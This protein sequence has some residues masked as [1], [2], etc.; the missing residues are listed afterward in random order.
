MSFVKSVLGATV[1]KILGDRAYWA[2]R[3]SDGSWRSE[4]DTRHEIRTG[5]VRPFDWSLDL[6]DTGDVLKIR[7]LWLFCPP[8]RLSPLGN[9]ARLPI[10]EP[11]TAFQFKVGNLFAV[12]ASGRNKAA[13]IIGRIDDKVSGACTCFIWDEELRAMGQPWQ[14][15]VNDFGTWRD[16]IMPIG[17]LD[18]RVLG[19]KL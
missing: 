5:T 19:V 9:T 10:V 3:L 15:N 1:G 12:G 7:E 14:T 6:V 17:E 4:L 8:N 13:Q 11:G 2:A 18:L 16:G